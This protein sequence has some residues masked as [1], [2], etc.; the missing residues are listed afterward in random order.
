MSVILGESQSDLSMWGTLASF[1][2]AWKN[3][4]PFAHLNQ[5]EKSIEKAHARKAPATSVSAKKISAKKV[6]AKKTPTKRAPRKRAS[7]KRPAGTPFDP[8]AVENVGVTLAVEL[9][10]QPLR[11]LPPKR[12]FA[13]AGVY[14]IYYKG[15]HAAYKEL[16]KLYAE[17][18]AP[19]YVGSALRENAKNGFNPQPSN[20]TRLFTRLKQHA[21]SIKE[22]ESEGLDP[23]FELS[24]FCCRF[25]VLNDAYILLAESVL[26]TTFRPAWN[27]MGFGSKVVGEK[28]VK[29][30]PSLW[31]SLHPGRGG[32]PKGTAPR[33]VTAKARIAKS[34]DELST[35]P[36]DPRSARMMDKIERFM[37][38]SREPSE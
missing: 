25:L 12:E 8:L 36:S 34:I 37:R 4:D 22:V 3:M 33:G 16:R 26:I 28:R 6:S 31:D 27:G 15:E 23:G 30:E 13:G 21:E 14:I 18:G 7:A 35:A 2:A 5:K 10:E 29:Q 32:R 11:P 9:L 20:S 24:D 1:K 38:G 17:E 19:V